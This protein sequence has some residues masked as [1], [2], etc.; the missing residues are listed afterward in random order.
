MVHECVA[1]ANQIAHDHG[2]EVEVLDLRCVRPIDEEAI[3]TSLSRTGRIVVATEDWPWGSV[4]AEV[5][6]VASHQGFHY[7]DAPPMRLCAL[8][9]PIPSHPALMA[10]Q[11]PN[12][13]RIAT[14]VLETV[15]Y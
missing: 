15:S 1:A 10:A 2:I 14:A 7:L 8:D 4:A 13:D 5:L 9:V 11:R 3:L 12:A 6:A